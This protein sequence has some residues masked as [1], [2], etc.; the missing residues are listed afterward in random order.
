MNAFNVRRRR[1]GST[2]VEVAVVIL[3]TLTIA[4]LLMPATVRHQGGGTRTQSTNNLRQIGFGSH[5][6]FDAN[7]RLPFNGVAEDTKQ[8]HAQYFQMARGSTF[9][10]GS[11]G[12]QISSYIDQGPMFVAGAS[13]NGVAT[14]MDPGRFRPGANATPNPWSDYIIN[15]WLN[16]DKA[17]DSAL[18]FDNK[19]TLIEITDGT[20]FTIFYGHGAVNTFDYGQSA[21]VPGY[22]D[23]ILKGGT[24]A[25]A[26]RASSG[27]ARDSAA[28]PRN[29][30]R[31][32]GSPYEMGCLMCMCDAT[33]RMFPY[34][35]GAADLQPFMTPNGKELVE[36][37][38]T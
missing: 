28:T 26:Q 25:T 32:W 20:S 1:S 30:E 10:S 4:A 33:V 29:A 36:L 31:G 16:D 37:P 35:L 6:F 38:D 7:K 11:W 3:A 24:G 15:P 9:T 23:T 5:S 21:V 22:L 12:F 34:S 27:F 8:Q 17:G 13:V 19:R 14:Y 18:N 2:R